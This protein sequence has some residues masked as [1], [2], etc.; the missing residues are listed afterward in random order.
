M[1]KILK[2]TTLSDIELDFLGVTVPASGQLT[3]DPEDY[4][5]LGT[6]DSTNEIDPFITSGDIVVNDGTNDLGI[7][8]GQ[9]FIRFPDNAPNI[10][11]DNTISGLI[12]TDV[13]NAIDELAGT[14]TVDEFAF[15]PIWAEE[16]AGL[17]NNQREW[18]FGNGATGDIGIVLPVDAQLYAVSY[19][20]DNAGTNTEIAVVQNTSSQ[21]AT[22]GPQSGEDGFNI[23]GTPVQFSAGDRLGFQTI[24]AGGASDVRVCAWMRVP[25][26]IAV[27]L[28]LGELNDV[29][30]T[31]ETN[32]Q[33]IAY[34]GSEW[35]NVDPE[36]TRIT[37][38]N[39]LSGLTATNVQEA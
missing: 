33:F 12:S 18:S 29:T 25:S 23:L 11:Y 10:R 26:S 9:N 31:G 27:D 5:D 6:D 32:G 36:A 17:G 14:V 8:A 4:L 34:N 21:V 3:I 15:F 1:A 28:S 38:D 22:T 30:L 20:A 7:T 19:N 16:N 13:K 35:I 37:Y 2:N 39:T 24:L